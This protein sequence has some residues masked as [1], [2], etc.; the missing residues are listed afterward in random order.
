MAALGSFVS[1]V[2][3]LVSLVFLYFQLRQ[4]SRELKLTEKNQRAM[5]Q[6]G[7]SARAS[8]AIMKLSEPYAS[9]ILH[10]SV[11]DRPLSG[12]ETRSYL[13]FV[14]AQHMSW[15]DT[16]LQ[17]SAGTLDSKSLETDEAALRFLASQPAYRAAWQMVR[18]QYGHD[19]R[20]YVDRII[21]EA[22]VQM[23]GDVAALFDTLKK[24]QTA[25]AAV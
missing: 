17:H 9:Q 2:A 11:S 21:G 14:M 25:L 13:G 4:V 5:M 12:P 23:P 8:D 6:Q 20:A 10:Q 24:E 18:L 15:E 7:R 1:G 16:F 3:V 19:Y 22:P